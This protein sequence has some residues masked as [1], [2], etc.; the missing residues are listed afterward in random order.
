MTT[1]TDPTPVPVTDDEPPAPDVPQTPEE[2]EEDRAFSEA[3]ETVSA[4]QPTDTRPPASEAPPSETPNAGTPDEPKAPEAKETPE[5][6]KPEPKYV[7]ITE[8][9]FNQLNALLKDVPELKTALHNLDGRV[10]S[11]LGDFQRTIK[12]ALQAKAD[13]GEPLEITIEDFDK[14]VAEDFP[15]IV[16][17][18]IRNVNK[19]LKGKG[20]PASAVV[21]AAQPATQPTAQSVDDPVQAAVGPLD[22]R[23]KQTLRSVMKLKRPNWLETVGE[24]DKDGKLPDNGFRRWLGTQPPEYQQKI[25]NTWD[26]EEIDGAIVQFEAFEAEEKKRTA[27]PAQPH[28]PRT[29]RFEAAIPQK[30]DRSGGGGKVVETED[31]GF[32]AGHEEASKRLAG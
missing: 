24:P 7:Q 22:T 19:A 18:I 6:P 9:Q 31:D 5:P 15:S 10:F 14:E 4:S 17:N 11:K 16:N 32:A 26:P 28:N 1:A 2:L 23:L 21:P 3:F 30:G 25:S 12:D 8:E 20:K 29:G 27:P 13:A